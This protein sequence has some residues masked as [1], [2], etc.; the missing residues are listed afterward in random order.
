MI[1]KLV[2]NLIIINLLA[3]CFLDFFQFYIFFN[4]D[5]SRGRTNLF[6]RSDTAAG[7]MHS[8]SITKLIKLNIKK[9]KVTYL[10]AF[11]SSYYHRLF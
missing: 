2:N 8:Y 6:D 4:H 10:I 9:S 3:F 5:I 1:M 11:K 7:R